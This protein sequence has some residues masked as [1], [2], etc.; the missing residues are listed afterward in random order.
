VAWA[1]IR[2]LGRL[3]AARPTL[4]LY[5]MHWNILAA[6]YVIHQNTRSI[7]LLAAQA[8]LSIVGLD[9]DTLALP[10]DV[11]ILLAASELGTDPSQDG[12]PRLG[13]GG[14]RATLEGIM[15]MPRRECL[16][17]FR[18]VHT[19]STESDRKLT[20][21]PRFDFGE[22]CELVHHL[23][24][25][26]AFKTPNGYVVTA[27][28]AVCLFCARFR[29]SGDQYDLVM[30]FD[31]SQSAILEIINTAIVLIDERWSHLLDF[32][33]EVLLSPKNLARYAAAIHRSGS[34]IATIWGFIDCTIRQICRPSW[35][36]CVVYNGHKK[37]HALKYQAVMLANGMI[38]H[39]FGPWEGRNAD[40]KLLAESLLLDKCRQYAVCPGTN[41]QTLPQ[42]RYYQLFGDAAYRVSPLMMSPFASRGVRTPDEL[43]WN[44]VMSSVRIEVEHGFGIVVNLWPFLNGFWKLCLFSSPVERYYCVG[45]LLTNA[46]NCL[47]PNQ[48][49][50]YFDCE[51]PTLSE[52]F[53][54]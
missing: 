35:R 8:M 15:R 23:R 21:H 16:W 29:S 27:F 52:Y 28:E 34:P 7:L 11:T 47:H 14:E 46:R 53:H 10:P 43:A 39:L 33:H 44:K 6:L 45:V 22:L 38:A 36:Q 40:T 41:E 26:E 50:M 32:D 51:P 24:L 9:L 2:A 42:D 49:S 48:V 1:P 54:D 17:H 20:V 19:C 4:D 3:C 31:R 5:T 30:R 13:Q 18:C 25:P 12:P 37:F